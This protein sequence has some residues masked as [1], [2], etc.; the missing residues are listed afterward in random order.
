MRPFPGGF[1]DRTV[2]PLHAQLSVMSRATRS[3]SRCL[4]A[5]RSQ[6]SSSPRNAAT[7]PRQPTDAVTSVVSAVCEPLVQS[8]IGV[9]CS[10]SSGTS[11]TARAGSPWLG[12]VAAARAFPGQ[13]TIVHPGWRACS[14]VYD[15]PC[16]FRPF[17][18]TSVI[19]PPLL[20]RASG[21]WM[22]TGRVPPA[23]ST[24][25]RARDFF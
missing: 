21:C 13:N 6:W 3:K 8:A 17:S 16:T 12:A 5:R 1:Q 15:T 10:F 24:P 11:A 23:L 2:V 18:S 22:R 9:G 25:E 14:F 7:G 20:D 19:T 4:R